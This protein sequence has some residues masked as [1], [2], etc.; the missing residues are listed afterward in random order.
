MM[1][2]KQRFVLDTSAFLC[3]MIREEG[4]SKEDA[5]R[6]LL[7][8]IATARLEL[9]IGC[10]IPPSVYK[11]LTRLLRQMGC[12]EEI[13][14]MLDT[15][16]VR[17]NPSSYEVKIP[18]IIIEEFILDV[19]NRI[20]KGLRVAEK[21]LRKLEE[22]SHTDGEVK[23]DE[24]ISELREKY[25]AALRRGIVDSKEDLDILVLAKELDAGVVTADEG[26][27]NWSEKFGLRCIEAEHFP[28]LIREYL[29]KVKGS[30]E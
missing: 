7:D 9:N 10:Y 1:L 20:D 15:W 11:E 21:A 28:A 23:A 5:I 4:E 24:L 29:R 27:L 3:D 26:I 14:V 16:L 19:R 2:A 17:K 13:F 18:S 30:G 12:D 6:R 22:K 25:R 8:L